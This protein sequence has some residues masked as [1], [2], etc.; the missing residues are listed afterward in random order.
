MVKHTKAGNKIERCIL[1]WCRPEIGAHCR[2]I[3][4]LP[5]I[6]SRYRYRRGGI[7][8][9]QHT[10]MRREVPGEATL[11]ASGIQASL[12][13]Q[14][15]QLKV[16]EVP[17]SEHLVLRSDVIEGGPLVTKARGGPLAQFISLSPSRLQVAVNKLHAMTYR[18]HKTVAIN[19]LRDRQQADRAAQALAET[20]RAPPL[21]DRGHECSSARGQRYS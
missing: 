8:R 15:V 9:Y 21:E 11:A 19:E 6:P 7:K 2:H 16:L 18:A 1:E 14:R 12:A 17:A 4:K 5:Q 13:P 10:E 3:C 20:A